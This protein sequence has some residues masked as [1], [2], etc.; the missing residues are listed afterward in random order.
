MYNDFD[1]DFGFDF[2]FDIK[3]IFRNEFLL[4]CRYS[5]LQI[6]GFKVFM[7]VLKIFQ[8]LHC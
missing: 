2:D 6:S 1:F 5:Y 3:V 7:V 4:V 8:E